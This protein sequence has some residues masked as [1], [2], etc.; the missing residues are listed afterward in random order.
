MCDGDDG[1][2]NI[3]EEEFKYILENKIITEN[4]IGNICFENDI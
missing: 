4:D 3:S 2:L 1:I